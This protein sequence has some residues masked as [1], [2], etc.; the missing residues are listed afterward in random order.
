MDLIAADLDRNMSGPRGGS[1]PEPSPR[2][3]AAC[4]ASGVQGD[5][6]T[7]KG[8]MMSE[9]RAETGGPNRT[10]R[11]K[12]RPA[13]SSNR[14]KEP[15]LLLDLSTSMNW[16]AADQHGPQ[17]PEPGS[18][19]AIVI[20]ALHGLVRVLEREDSEA[21]AE[22]AG[23]DDELGGLMTHG[24]ANR[25]VEIGDLNSSNLQRRLNEIK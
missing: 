19:R 2:C 24:F 18:R 9:A 7:R 5:I 22:Q 6:H 13:V 8:T 23:G 16:G 3:A 25:H 20:E 10:P 11:S 15:V 12:I 4:G 21:A 17:W 1:R 14:K